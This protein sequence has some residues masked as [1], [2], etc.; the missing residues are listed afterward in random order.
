MNNLEPVI[1]NFR[2][3]PKIAS[4]VNYR[5]AI[6]N[7]QMT[8]SRGLIAEATRY[9]NEHQISLDVFINASN[10]S[11]I[12]DDTEA[13]IMEADLF[14][15]QSLGTDGVIIGALTSENQ[16]DTEIMEALAGASDGMEM[17]F[18]PA[19]D[20]IPEN[21]WDEALS[22]LTEHQFSGIVASQNLQKLEQK[23]KEFNTLR[24]VPYLTTEEASQ[25]EN[26]TDSFIY[27]N[28]K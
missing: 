18:S 26:Q 11:N 13:K 25:P 20:E 19:F 14:Q 15:C 7:N 9:A 23:L 1:D 6:A 17:F 8:P 24:L 22:W 2:E 12:F 4:K 16:I 27:I 21:N 5:I 3:L 10:E 28:K